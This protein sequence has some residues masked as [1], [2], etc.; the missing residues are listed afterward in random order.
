[1]IIEAAL[2]DL[3]GTLV[4]SLE[5][6]TDAVNH[7]LKEFGLPLLHM[8]EVRQLVGKGARN[9]VQ[10]ALGTDSPD[11]ITRGVNLFKEFN[12]SHIADKSTLYAGI[13]DLLSTLASRRIR[14]AI[15]SNKS[16]S[17]CRLIL[18][19]LKISDFFEII[20]GGDTFIE[21]KPSPLPLVKVL[22]ML[23]IAPDK[24]IMIGDSINDIQAGVRAGITTIGCTWGYGGEN[25]FQGADYL[26]AS[27]SK[28]ADI[29]LK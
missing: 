21:M 22:E 7:M 14:M 11:E 2:F 5:D 29:L 13:N 15:V 28:L 10:R 16:E 26:A 8:A 20:S 12:S 3:D 24:A 25:D 19:T 18:Q 1:M 23:T 27:G 6:L 4:D 9:L 17:L